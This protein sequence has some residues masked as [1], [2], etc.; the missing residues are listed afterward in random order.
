MV[1]WEMAKE[2]GQDQG[3]GHAVEGA[4]VV[5]LNGDPVRVVS[6]GH[7][8]AMRDGAHAI[9][10]RYAKLVVHLEEGCESE[11]TFHC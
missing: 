3:S 4:L 9:L 8:D 7:L 6:H 2:L 10:A 1:V 5:K 11:A